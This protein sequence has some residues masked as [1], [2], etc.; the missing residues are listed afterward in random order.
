MVFLAGLVAQDTQLFGVTVEENIAYGLDT[1]EYTQEDLEAAADR[2][3]AREFI[4]SKLSLMLSIGRHSILK[5]V[6]QVPKAGSY[7][8]YYNI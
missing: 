4:E 7:Y 3:N 2:A 5:A 6:A 1:S 8:T